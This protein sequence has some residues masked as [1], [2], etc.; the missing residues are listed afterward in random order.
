MMCS[1]RS[2]ARLDLEPGQIVLH[3][4]LEIEFSFLAK[5]NSSD[6]DKRFRNRADL[7]KRV[8]LYGQSALNISEAILR[9]AYQTL[10]VRDRN[11]HAG[12]ADFIHVARDEFI[13]LLKCGL[14]VRWLWTLA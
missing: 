11:R 10:A 12:S 6:T 1:Y 13:Q 2:I 5:L 3:W 8:R 9:C 7:E 4:F 14:K